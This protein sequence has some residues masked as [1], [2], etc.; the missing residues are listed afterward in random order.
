MPAAPLRYSF[1]MK[2]ALVLLFLSA[3]VG[4][5]TTKAPAKAEPAAAKPVAGASLPSTDAV[6]EFMRHMLGWD[7]NTKWQVG[8]IK[9]TESG[10]VEALVG[11][12]TA[13]GQQTLRLFI[14]PDGQHAINGDLVPF[15]ADPF[16]RARDLLSK[17]NGAAHGPADAALT[18]VE[19]GDLQCP[20][21]KAAQPLVEKI[22]AENPNARFIFQNY[23]LPMHNWA[24]KAAYWADCA[25]R[26]NADA[27]WKWVPSVYAQQADI[28]LETVD[29][30]LGTLL[31]TAGGDVRVVEACVAQP[32]TKARV[33]A[34]MRLGDSVEVGGT[35]TLFF[36]GRKIAN[37]SATPYEVLDKIIKFQ[38][39]K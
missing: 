30:K 37:V 18:I 19:F 38:A 22:L 2:R 1:L 14:T 4:A 7:P 23:P 13:Q 31:A 24:M 28:T 26:Q 11:I 10:L 33:E 16:A 6:N 29:Q 27:F 8:S 12:S 5:Q 39:Q 9:M 21:C 36:N 35:P 20:S 3:L 25:A 32:D 15:A 34:S 17:G